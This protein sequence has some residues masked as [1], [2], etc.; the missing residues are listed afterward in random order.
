MT[1]DSLYIIGARIMEKVGAACALIL[2]SYILEGAIYN[3]F[4]VSI[5]S[6]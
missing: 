2:K 1:L 5:E 6:A 4:N 3:S